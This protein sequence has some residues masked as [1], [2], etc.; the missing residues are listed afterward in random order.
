MEAKGEA[1]VGR[2]QKLAEQVEHG[3][4]RHV[5]VPKLPLVGYGDTVRA[6]FLMCS[7]LVQV[8]IRAQWTIFHEEVACPG[9]PSFEARIDVSIQGEANFNSRYGFYL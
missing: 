3:R 5:G 7:I 8:L 9:P 1:L 6:R 2:L 4:T